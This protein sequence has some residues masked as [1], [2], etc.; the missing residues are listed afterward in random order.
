M[1]VQ[2]HMSL[3]GLPHDA[4]LL[5]RSHGLPAT[6]IDHLLHP[7][8]ERRGFRDEQIGAFCKF[9]DGIARAGIPRKHNHAVRRFKA[10]GIGLVLAGSRAFME[11]QNGCFR[12]PSL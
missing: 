9:S 7:T 1:I 4:G 11:M 12:R 8:L 5:D 3:G 2:G 6:A 10:I